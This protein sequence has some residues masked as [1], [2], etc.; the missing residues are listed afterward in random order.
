MA[1]QMEVSTDAGYHGARL[2]WVLNR[3][4]NPYTGHY[5]GV[6]ITIPP[7]KEKI[8]KLYRDGGNLM[9]YLEACEFVT[10]LKEPQRFEPDSAGKMNP[11]F[12]PKAL[13]RVE[14]TQEEFD[15][16]VGKSKEQVK[17][18]MAQDERKAR[19]RLNSEL[20]K[21]PNKIAVGDDE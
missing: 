15:K 9:P 10:D 13:M 17:K 2:V 20:N 8:G 1:A 3:D 19:K 16:Y 7:E 21:I 4:E 18:E 5:R 6:K 14:L 11:I 12:G